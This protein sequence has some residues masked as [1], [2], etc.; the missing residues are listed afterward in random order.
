MAK[1]SMTKEK[2]PEYPKN[3]HLV[4]RHLFKIL[5]KIYVTLYQIRFCCDRY[6]ELITAEIKNY[7]KSVPLR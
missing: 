4:C 1:R 7:W 3:K 6:L 2:A 5:D